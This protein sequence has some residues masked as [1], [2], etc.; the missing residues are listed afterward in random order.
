MHP[1]ALG[2]DD[3]MRQC[4]WGR[5]RGSG[6]GG[7][8]RNKVETKV[9]ITHGPTGIEAAASE[10]RS[11]EE[12][13]RVALF[14]LR[15]RLATELRHAV[16]DGNA[17]SGLWRSRTRDGKITCN[18]EHHDYPAMLAEALDVMEA[19]RLDV[20]RAALRLGT[21]ASQLTKLVK[22]HPP[23]FTRLNEARRQRGLGSLR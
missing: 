17:A 13:K 1:A 2:N 3:L 10:R 14:R 4:E 18:P 12:N 15:L 21:T 16:P 8:H 5:S 7:Q 19:C 11:A 6:P 23:A 20:P 22:D 9:T